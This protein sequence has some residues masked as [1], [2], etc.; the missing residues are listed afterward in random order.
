M[1]T[2]C[3]AVCWCSWRLTHPCRFQRL[4]AYDQNMHYLLMELKTSA[5]LCR[6]QSLCACNHMHHPSVDIAGVIQWCWKLKACSKVK[7]HHYAAS[8]WLTVKTTNPKLVCRLNR[9]CACHGTRHWFS[10]GLRHQQ[11]CGA[12]SQKGCCH[13]LRWWTYGKV[14][15]PIHNGTS[16]CWALMPWCTRW[17]WCPATLGRPVWERGSGSR[18][19]FSRR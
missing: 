9:W 19:N 11:S 1:T 12:G 17:C 2:L 18:V 15:C 10:W 16:S 4:H 8:S 14:F 13:S 6:F 5:P 7:L 3:L